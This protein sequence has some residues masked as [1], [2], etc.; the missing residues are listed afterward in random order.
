MQLPNEIQD[1]IYLFLDYET[2]ENSRELQSE[3]IKK[4]TKW[5]DY[6]KAI[7][8]RNL[9]NVKWLYYQQKLKPKATHLQTAARLGQFEIMKFLYSVNCPMNM[10]VSQAAAQFGDL[11]ILK[12]TV[13]ILNHSGSVVFNAAASSG[14]LEIMKW[15][16]EIKLT[17][18][19]RTFICAIQNGNLDNLK[20]L[21]SVDCPRC[22]D[23]FDT[24]IIQGDLEIL[25]WLK[26]IN[27]PVD[28]SHLEKVVGNI[29]NK[30]IATWAINEMHIELDEYVLI[31]AV[32]VKKLEFIKWLR[33]MGCAWDS[34]VYQEALDSGDQEIIN[35]LIENGCP[36]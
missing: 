24:A 32:K 27:C 18:T 33:E 11:E 36:Q 9:D 6:E 10:Y 16:H 19:E 3:Y 21:Y 5:D 1:Q 20:W 8:D 17:M 2:L 26:E 15:L 29:C 12:W 30:E 28:L 34:S 4:V 35:W 22:F 14:N 7:R 25:K 31:E 23:A 13:K